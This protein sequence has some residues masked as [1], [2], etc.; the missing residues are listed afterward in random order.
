M[1]DTKVIEKLRSLDSAMKEGK[2]C[3]GLSHAT[4]FMLFAVKTFESMVSFC[5]TSTLYIFCCFTF[6]LLS[7]LQD[8]RVLGDEFN[9]VED[10]SDLDLHSPD[11]SL[12]LDDDTVRS[13]CIGIAQLL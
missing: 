8:I 13:V 4:P 6:F 2:D 3:S 1:V 10:E 9:R 5:N 11:D 7:L 12:V